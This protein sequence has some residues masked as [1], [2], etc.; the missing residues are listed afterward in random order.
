MAKAAAR[1]MGESGRRQALRRPPEPR[2]G[3]RPVGPH[4][5]TTDRT[6][7]CPTTSRVANTQPLP[8]A[9]H[10]STVTTIG[11]CIMTLRNLGRGIW[12]RDNP[13]LI[14]GGRGGAA[15]AGQSSSSPAI[16][17]A[18]ADIEVGGTWSPPVRVFL[19]WA[20]ANRDPRR[21][22]T[23][24]ASTDAHGQRASRVRQQH[25]HLLRR[26]GWRGLEINLALGGV[27]AAGRNRRGWWWTH[28]LYRHNQVFPW[29]AA[30]VGGLRRDRGTDPGL[31]F[32]NALVV[33]AD[34]PHRPMRTIA[35]SIAAPDVPGVVI[36]RC[37]W[38]GQRA[39]S[40]E[41]R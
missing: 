34:R 8:I 28:A 7:Q 5:T 15:A 29:S 24:T 32:S 4:C 23:W 21:F 22:R 1:G 37:R 16:R 25:P 18:T 31:L 20:A 11:N 6:A 35:S 19:V 3:T 26:T 40:P 2:T 41:R 36:F 13:D 27:P 38:R 9:G 10:D 17:W 39:G 14:P 12:V 30:S 33:A